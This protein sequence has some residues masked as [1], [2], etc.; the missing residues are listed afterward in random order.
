MTS[1]WTLP[2]T[3]SP[4]LDDREAILDALYRVVNAFDH[5]DEDLLSSAFTKDSKFIL[6]GFVMDGLAAI[7]KDSFDRVS[8]LNTTHFITNTRINID[9]GGTTAKL[10]ANALAQHYRTGTGLAEAGD[11]PRYLAASFYMLDLVKQGNGMW[12]ITEFNMKVAWGE[13]DRSVLSD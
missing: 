3:L 5:D 4:P 7:R 13:G 11:A 2:A 9:A 6:S 1:T 12:K 8:K 10:S